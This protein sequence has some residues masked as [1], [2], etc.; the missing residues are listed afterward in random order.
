VD[1]E[2]ILQKMSSQSGVE[3]VMFVDSEGETIHC[4]GQYPKD[5][6]HVIGAYQGIVL[7]AAERAG[8]K[9]NR[10]IV[11]LYQQHNI[12]TRRLKDGYFISVIFSKAHFASVHFF[13]EEYCCQLEREL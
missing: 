2:P 10:A 3:A 12:L 8:L 6:L 13:I 5:Q 11:T 1:F 7:S 4:L 9:E